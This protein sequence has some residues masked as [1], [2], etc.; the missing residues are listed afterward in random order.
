M[1]P[2]QSGGSIKVNKYFADAA[3]PKNIYLLL[4]HRTPL[5]LIFHKL[6]PGIKK[7]PF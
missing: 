4:L 7:K 2:D 6:Y 3:R 5:D 1:G